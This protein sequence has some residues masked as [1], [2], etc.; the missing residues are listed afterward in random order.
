MSQTSKEY[1][2]YNLKSQGFFDV[3]ESEAATI[4]HAK[5]IAFVEAGTVEASPQ[6]DFAAA[7]RH[8][9]KAQMASKEFRHH[10]TGRL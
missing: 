6:V 7:E 5:I 10:I 8:R 9:N 2:P 3:I 1:C 4:Q